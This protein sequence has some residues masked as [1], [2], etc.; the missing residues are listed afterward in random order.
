MCSG[1]HNV[2]SNQLPLGDEK[3]SNLIQEKEKVALDTV[4]GVSRRQLSSVGQL[5]LFMRK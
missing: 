3:D 5:G 4:L 2:L 1:L